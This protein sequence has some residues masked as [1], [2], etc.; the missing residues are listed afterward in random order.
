MKLLVDT[1]ILIDHLR[2]RRAAVE[3]LLAA[4]G[5][6]DDLWAVTVSRTEVLRG[7]RTGEAPRTVRLLSS[8]SWLDVTP[9]I[10]DRAGELGRRYRQSHPGID[11]V[12]LVIAAAAEALPAELLTLNVKHFP[13]LIGLEPAYR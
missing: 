2:D 5:R 9:D 7:M 12:D 1:S 10:A 8:L 3:L 4:V 6:G 13:M 11:V